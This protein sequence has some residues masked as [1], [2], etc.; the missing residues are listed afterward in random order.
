MN[1]TMNMNTMLQKPRR[2]SLVRHRLIA[3]DEQRL[4]ESGFP[5]WVGAVCLFVGL[6]GLAYGGLK[7]IVDHRIDTALSAVHPVLSSSLVSLVLGAICVLIG[8]VLISPQ[9]PEH[10][11]D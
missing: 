2:R 9:E 11:S 6:A 8:I 5:V 10:Y 3:E 4:H 7:M 1:T